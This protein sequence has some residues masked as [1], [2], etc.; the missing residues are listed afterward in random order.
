MFPELNEIGFSFNLMFLEMNEIEFYFNSMYLVMN[1]I[2]FCS[3]SMFLEMNEIAS[4]PFSSDSMYADRD[5]ALGSNFLFTCWSKKKTLWGNFNQ[6]K[7]P[8]IWKKKFPHIFGNTKMVLK[9]FYF[10]RLFFRYCAGDHESAI[11]K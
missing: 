11:F 3:N 5:R 2:A 1:E 8:L 6:K 4:E 10:E 9:S 7:Y